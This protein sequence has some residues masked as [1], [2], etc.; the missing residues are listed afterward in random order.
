MKKII[1]YVYQ[2]LKV[3]LGHKDLGND[4]PLSHENTGETHH[5]AIFV[6]QRNCIW[7]CWSR[8][9]LLKDLLLHERFELITKIMQE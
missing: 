9:A 2:S 5:T 1:N 3:H 4:Y 6:Y 7:M 8:T